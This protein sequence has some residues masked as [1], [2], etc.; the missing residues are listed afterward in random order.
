[1]S[2]PVTDRIIE[3]LVDVIYRGTYRIISAFRYRSNRSV[4]DDIIALSKSNDMRA[5]DAAHGFMADFDALANRLKINPNRIKKM[6]STNISMIR[7]HDYRLASFK[8]SSYIILCYVDKKPEKGDR[9]C[10]KRALA[11]EAEYHQRKREL[12]SGGK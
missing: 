8:D 6:K 5:R 7:Q 1:M 4:H 9:K 10:L 3:Q 12:M 11:R 2:P